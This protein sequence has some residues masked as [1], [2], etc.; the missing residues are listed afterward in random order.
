MALSASAYTFLNNLEKQINVEGS[1]FDPPP[2]FL[3][4]N[5]LNIEQPE[6]IALG[7]FYVAGV[8]ESDIAIDRSQVGKNPDIFIG[9]QPDPLY[10][11]DPCDPMCVTF[12]GGKCGVKPCPPECNSMPDI[13]YIP[14]NAW[15]LPY[16]RCDE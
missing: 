4:G 5:I 3:R 2:S 14:P 1:I 7:Y 6:K 16:K 11:G 10:C 8:A 9:L 13:T 12:G 15:P